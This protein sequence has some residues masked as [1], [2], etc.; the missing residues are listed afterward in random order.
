MEGGS[1]SR[2]RDGCR[3]RAA[4]GA[5]PGLCRCR[6]GHAGSVLGPCHGTLGQVS[7]M[8]WVPGAGSPALCCI[9]VF[10]APVPALSQEL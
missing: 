6:W 10:H 4:A 2:R 7:E 3:P 9:V 1:W 8:L 5:V